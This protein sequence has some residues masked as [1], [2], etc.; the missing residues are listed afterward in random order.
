M[1][2]QQ[3]LMSTRDNNKINI[4]SYEPSMTAP[5]TSLLQAP[6]ASS[7]YCTTLDNSVL[8][9]SL[10]VHELATDMATDVV[11]A[12]AST[13]VVGAG[14]G[15]GT[16]TYKRSNLLQVKTG[17]ASKRSV[18]WKLS[19]IAE[20]MTSPRGTFSASSRYNN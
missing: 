11:C 13:A 12:V 20:M 15:T 10:P 4:P 5:N 6:V 1:Q 9:P 8:P 16:T 3:L 2:H 14:A 7:E 19:P 18:S 17:P